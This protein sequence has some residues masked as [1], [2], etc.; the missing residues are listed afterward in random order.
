MA[1]IMEGHTISSSTSPAAKASPSF[2]FHDAIPPSDMVGDMAGM[3]NGATACLNDDECSSKC[4]GKRM[5]KWKEERTSGGRH[6]G[7]QRP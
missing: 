1:R 7:L 4:L 2:I 6:G 5:C 3:R